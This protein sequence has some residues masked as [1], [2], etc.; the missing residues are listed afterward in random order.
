MKYAE[1]L[2]KSYNYLIDGS[3]EEKKSKVIKKFFIKRKLKF[4]N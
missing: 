1:K 2:W 3:I 4:E